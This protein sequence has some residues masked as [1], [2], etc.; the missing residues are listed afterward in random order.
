[1][2]Q[3]AHF[4]AITKVGLHLALETGLAVDVVQV[5]S[6]GLV[7]VLGLFEVGLEGLAFG[8]V[9]RELGV[10]VGEE[11]VVL[12]EVDLYLREGTGLCQQHGY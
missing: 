12:V 6:V 8:F 11:L 5:V 2:V 7:G 10:L 9:E 4:P 3:N 1:V